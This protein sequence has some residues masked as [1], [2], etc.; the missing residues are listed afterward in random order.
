[1]AGMDDDGTSGGAGRAGLDEL[2]D[3]AERVA[4][5]AA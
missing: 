4:T 3:L 2:A 1:M 5:Q